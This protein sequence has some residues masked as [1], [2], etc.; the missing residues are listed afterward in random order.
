MPIVEVKLWEGRD[1]STKR[2]L[3]EGITEVFTSL[4]TPA[5]AVTVILTEYPKSNWGQNGKPAA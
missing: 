2:K 3:I 5:T 4:G 1:N